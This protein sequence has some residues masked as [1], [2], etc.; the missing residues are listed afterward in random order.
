MLARPGTGGSDTHY[1]HQMGTAATLFQRRI[2]SLDDLIAELKAGRMRPVA[3]TTA[4]QPIPS[5]C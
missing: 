2:T 1:P 3:L 4:R 5:A